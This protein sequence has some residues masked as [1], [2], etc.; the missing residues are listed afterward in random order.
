MN[1]LQDLR[2]DS[3]SSDMDRMIDTDAL[4]KSIST[5][6]N[7]SSS[8]THLSVPIPLSNSSFTSG[9]LEIHSPVSRPCN[10]M[11]AQQLEYMAEAQLSDGKNKTFAEPILCDSPTN[12]AA[13]VVDKPE[14]PLPVR[15]GQVEVVEPIKAAAGVE[16][17]NSDVMYVLDDCY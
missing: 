12:T 17:A 7:P 10:N 6:S 11:T 14:V 8:A 4:L 1:F 2:G 3:S 15:K 5:F 13:E 16:S 9:Q